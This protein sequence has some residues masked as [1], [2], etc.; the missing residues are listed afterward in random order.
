MS[1]A[2]AYVG[3]PFGHGPGQETCWT[4][5]RR[6]YREQLGIDLPEFGDASAAYVAAMARLMRRR[7]STDDLRA[8]QAV[9]DR[10]I[11]RGQA[12]AA[13]RAVARPRAFD[14]A[15]VRTGDAIRHVGV[16]VDPRRLLH[17]ERASHAVIVPVAHWSVRHRMAGYRRHVRSLS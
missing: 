3:I 10:E 16:M 9:V 13:W 17:V 4:L 2:Q 8:A 14:V 12:G 15:L 7:G 6:V 1:W 11:E 5:I